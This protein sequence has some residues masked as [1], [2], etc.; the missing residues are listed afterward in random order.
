MDSAKELASNLDC[1]LPM[2][3]VVVPML[4]E[5]ENLS[6][7]IIAIFNVLAPFCRFEV[8]LVDDGSKDE[9]R[10]I[11]LDLGLPQSSGPVSVLVHDWS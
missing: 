8:V 11:A 2:V 1:S 7:L 10:A 6:P 3:S 9:T 4:D 5:A